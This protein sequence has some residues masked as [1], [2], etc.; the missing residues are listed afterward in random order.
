[1]PLKALFHQQEGIDR[2]IRLSF[3]RNEKILLCRT[4][5]EALLKPFLSILM[6]EICYLYLNYAHY[7]EN[8]SCIVVHLNEYRTYPHIR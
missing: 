1:M 2:L 7:N 4:C 8:K 5:L 3:T 6:K